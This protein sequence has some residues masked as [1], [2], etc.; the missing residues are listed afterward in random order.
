MMGIRMEEPAVLLIDN[1]SVIINSTLPCSTLKK[2]HNAIAYHKVRE[3]VAA[4]FV[5]I[6]HVCSKQN[7][8]DILTKPLGPQDYFR[9]LKDI[10]FTH[11]EKQEN[12]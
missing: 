1:N 11:Q 8:A 12:P 2:K 3:A 5:R 9:L 10:M 7:R 6:A 4:G